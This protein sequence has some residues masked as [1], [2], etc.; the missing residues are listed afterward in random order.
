MLVSKLFRLPLFFNSTPRPSN[1]YL[2]ALSTPH[3]IMQH[4][5]YNLPDPEHGYA[6]DDNARALIVAHLWKNEDRNTAVLMRNLEGAYLRF[7]K[8]AQHE[9]GTFYCYVSFDLQKKQLGTGDWFGR[10]LFS[11]AFILYD[12]QKYGAVSWKILKKSLL[13]LSGHTFSLKTTSFLIMAV[14]YLLKHNEKTKLLRGYEFDRLKKLLRGWRDDFYKRAKTHCTPDWFW[15]EDKITYDNGKVIQAYFFLG[16]LLDDDRMTKFAEKMLEFY[17][18]I[19]FKRGYFQAPGNRGFWQKNG[20]RP[21]YDEQGVEAYSITAALITA[22][23]ILENKRYLSLA[24][25]TY[26][27]FWGKNRLKKSMVDR[28]SGAVYDALEKEGVND[29]QGAE[30]C[31]SLHLAYFALTHKMHL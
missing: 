24:N 5:M 29:N 12:S 11:L 25:E 20:K 1:G 7:L 18:K 16:L 21:K 26:R 23:K 15:P 14:Y 4:T 13:Q 10:S 2:V 31:L 28:R 30:S 6:T 3:G 27:W 17:I 9:D 19:T 22:Y 8:F